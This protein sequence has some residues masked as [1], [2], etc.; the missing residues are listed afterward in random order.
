MF[1]PE[2]CQTEEIKKQRTYETNRNGE[3]V[4]SIPSILVITINIIELVTP[5]KAPIL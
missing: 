5:I 2:D 4:D 1:N 3:I